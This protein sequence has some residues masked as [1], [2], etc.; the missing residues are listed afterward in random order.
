MHQC[1]FTLVYTQTYIDGTGS[2]HIND[3]DKG[4]FVDVDDEDDMEYKI[5]V[6]LTMGYSTAEAKHALFIHNNVLGK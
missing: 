2:S 1:W 3:K 4:G 6:L 5:N